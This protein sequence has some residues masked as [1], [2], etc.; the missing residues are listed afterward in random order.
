[1]IFTWFYSKWLFDNQRT[2]IQIV[3]HI[4]TVNLN[5]LWFWFL[6]VTFHLAC[7]KKHFQYVQELTI[8]DLETHSSLNAE[9]FTH[10]FQL[11]TAHHDVHITQ[12]YAT[13]ELVLWNR[14]TILTVEVLEYLAKIGYFIRLICELH[15][16]L[17]AECALIKVKEAVNAI[18]IRQV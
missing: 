16:R 17:W 3:R 9:T 2:L 8:V 4:F 5:I 15:Q 14:S 12:R 6:I 1:M 10:S 7:G 18:Q 13:Q 11:A